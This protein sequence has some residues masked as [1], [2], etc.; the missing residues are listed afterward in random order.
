MRVGSPS[1][2]GRVRSRL[3]PTNIVEVGSWGA[4]H[5]DRFEESNGI[6]FPEQGFESGQE[7]AIYGNRL[8]GNGGLAIQ[9][10]VVY[11]DD[12]EPK[13]AKPYGPDDQ[14][15]VCGNEI[16]GRTHG[17]PTSNCP[18]AVPD[19]DGIGHLGGDSPWS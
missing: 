18:A 14:A 17:T 9:Y 13:I 3:V 19:G 8:V 16:S 6:P 2:V 15:A 5:P 1:A 4:A 7:N 12:G 11:P 10:P